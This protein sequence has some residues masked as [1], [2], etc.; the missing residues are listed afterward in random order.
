MTKIMILLIAIIIVE[1][2]LILI[3]IKHNKNIKQKINTTE[4]TNIDNKQEENIEVFNSD[5]Y[6]D[7]KKDTLDLDELFKTISITQQDY[8]FDFGLKEN[9][10]K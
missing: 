4:P 7:E 1:I 3:A 2:V 6:K 10:K 5:D 8:D 9:N